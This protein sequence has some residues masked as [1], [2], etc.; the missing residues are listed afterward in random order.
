MV[1]SS[2]FQ[3]YDNKKCV[4]KNSVS[5]WLCSVINEAY[6]TSAETDYRAVKAEM[7]SIGISTLFRKNFAVQQVLRAS[8]GIS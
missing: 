3:L 6:K 7:C 4:S 5:F 2:L 1:Q 8:T